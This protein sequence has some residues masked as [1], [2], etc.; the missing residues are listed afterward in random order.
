MPPTAN[1]VARRPFYIEAI[2]ANSPVQVNHARLLALSL[3]LIVTASLSRAA[4]DDARIDAGVGM[5]DITP[6]EEVVLAG[7]PS[8]KRTSEVKT[9]LFVRALVL[10][11]SSRKV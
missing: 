4:A 10:S 11:A 7:S 9:H 2:E 8:P 1:C 6:T 5:V 3:C